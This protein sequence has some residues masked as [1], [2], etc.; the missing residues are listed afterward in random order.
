M[1]NVIFLFVF[2]AAFPARADTR[3]VPV[4]AVAAKAQDVPIVREGLGTVQ[5]LNTATI[6][7]QVSGQLTGIAFK[8][9]QSIRTGQL[10]AQIDPAPFQAVVDQAVATL[11]RDKATLQNSRLNL[12]R[13][14]PLADR[15]YATSQQLDTQSSVVDQGQSTLKIDEAQVSAAKVQLAFTSIVAPF[16]GVLGIRLVDVGNVVHPTDQTGLVVLTQVQPISVVFALPSADIPAVQDALAR[17]TV[18][19]T[20]YAADDR[21]LLDTGRLLLINNQADP[22][23][24]TVTLKAQFPNARDKLWPGTFVNV[25]VVVDTR[26]NGLTVPS[27]AVQ[28][29]PNGLYVYVIASD[30]SVHLTPVTIGQARGGE[31][32]VDTGLSAGAEVV[33]DGQYGLSDGT[34]VSVVSGEAAKQVQSSTSAAAGMLP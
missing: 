33:T 30:D 29:G 12:S 26:R 4:T 9:G 28:Q 15:G 21:T 8:E 2:L 34:K 6:R 31:T 25:H 1:K 23:S 7:V 20:A 13:T 3:P 18:T 24:G 5:A 14:A 22:N 16:D 27:T 17:G 10:L 32:L 11:A 19:A